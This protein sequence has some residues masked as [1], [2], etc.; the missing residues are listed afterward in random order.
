VIARRV[1]G[2][3][4][5]DS[6]RVQYLQYE[7]LKSN[8]GAETSF[9]QIPGTFL[10]LS[11]TVSVPGLRINTNFDGASHFKVTA[12]SLAGAAPAESSHLNLDKLSMVTERHRETSSFRTPKTT[13]N[14]A[15]LY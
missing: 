14:G 4:K 3:G 8:R 9:S 15:E 12:P 2:K 10:R 6:S 1:E 7:L 13:L 11:E 5:K